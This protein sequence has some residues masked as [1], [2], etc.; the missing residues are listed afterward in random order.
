VA[1]VDWFGATAVAHPAPVRTPR[2]DPRPARTPPAA[3]AARAG[4][5]TRHQG[6][7]LTGSI[8]W[9]ALFAVLLTGVV[10]LNVAVLR[11]N[12]GVSK[13]DKT[14]IQLQAENQALSSQVSSAASA[15]RIETAARKLGLVPA[16]STDTSYLD[17]GGNG[18]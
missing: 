17:I 4:T 7:R 5:R 2:R 11:T 14:E 16:Q 15:S 10:A 13:L 8:V 1:A 9:I 6:R 3:P 18:K 12:M